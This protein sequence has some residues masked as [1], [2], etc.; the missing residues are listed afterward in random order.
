M[1]KIKNLPVDERPRE[2]ALK[3]GIE[4]LS[5]VELLAII[6]NSGT[7]NE[8]A[9]DIAHKIIYE[10]S[11]LNNLHLL[12]IN[13]LCSFKGISLANALKIKSCFELSNRQFKMVNNTENYLY[14]PIKIIDKYK[15]DLYSEDK[16]ILLIVALN[17]RNRVVKE[18][19]FTMFSIDEV[20]VTLINILNTLIDC[21]AKKYYVF[22]NHTSGDFLPSKNDILITASLKEQTNK[23]GI[24]MVDHIIVG[25][26]C[27]YSF[28]NKCSRKYEK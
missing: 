22:H 2:K 21:R 20:R 3:Y 28:L 1:G 5:D 12:T 27:Y 4:S 14:D 15:I 11:G 6:I 26:E 13:D 10:N 16:E 7:K 25:K 18:K 24:K 23:I 17:K 19:F 8:S 9:I